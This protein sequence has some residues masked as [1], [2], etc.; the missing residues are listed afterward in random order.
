MTYR[1]F[2][3]RKFFWH[4]EKNLIGHQLMDGWMNL[5]YQD[6]S[7]KCIPKFKECMYKLEQDFHF[8]QKKQMEKETGTTIITEVDRE[9]A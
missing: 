7:I 6:G 8:Y 4:T 5:Y 2:W 1:L 9:R 3:K